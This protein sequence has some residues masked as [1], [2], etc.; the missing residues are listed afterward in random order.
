MGNQ[1]QGDWNNF[2]FFNPF[3][4]QVHYHPYCLI[5]DF[6]NQTEVCVV[7]SVCVYG[8]TLHMCFLSLCIWYDRACHISAEWYSKWYSSSR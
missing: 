4:Q 7:C 6:L 2:T 1:R 3:N 8:H 5:E